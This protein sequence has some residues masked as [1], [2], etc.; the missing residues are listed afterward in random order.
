[1][2]RQ[3]FLLW[4]PHCTDRFVLLRKYHV[5]TKPKKSVSAWKAD[6]K[7]DRTSPLLEIVETAKR[8]GAV[9]S[10]QYH[11]STRG[12]A[13]MCCTATSTK[14]LARSV[15]DPYAP[16]LDGHVDPTDKTVDAMKLDLPAGVD[17][18]IKLQ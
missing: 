3:K 13:L 9:V 16:T 12:S 5:G 1:L 6:Y 8:T 7:L 15:R 18:E 11:C 10:A 2:L 14:L 4:R 17:V